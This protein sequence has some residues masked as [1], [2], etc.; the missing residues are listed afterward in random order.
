MSRYC[1]GTLVLQRNAPAGMRFAT[2]MTLRQ[3]GEM[4]S[5]VCGQSGSGGKALRVSADAMPTRSAP[6]SFARRFTRAAS[7]PS[8]ADRRE[9]GAFTIP[10][11]SGDEPARRLALL[12]DPTAQQPDRVDLPRVAVHVDARRDRK[13]TRLNSSHLG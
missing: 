12:G 7:Q 1:T 10:R 13:S 3:Y 8:P 4:R 11:G 9:T 6:S 2:T 5:G